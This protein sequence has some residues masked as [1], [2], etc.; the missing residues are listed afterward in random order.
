[1]IIIIKMMIFLIIGHLPVCTILTI[2]MIVIGSEALSKRHPK[3]LAHVYHA[4][5][6]SYISI[7]PYRKLNWGLK[8]PGMFGGSFQKMLNKHLG[9][10][11]R[12]GNVR[13]VAELL[14][15]GANVNASLGGFTPLT[16]A[17]TRGHIDVCKLLLS[18]G[19]SVSK[20]ESGISPLMGAAQE[21]H[22][23]ICKLLLETYMQKAGDT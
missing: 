16:A 22:S 15:M 2:V 13:K 23:V 20:S 14:S 3:N 5:P 6:A 1:M 17:A 7:K 19:A 11:A 4:P 18:K 8:R 9:E 12:E 21:G 10:E